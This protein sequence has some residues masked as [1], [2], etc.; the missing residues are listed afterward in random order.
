MNHFIF[1]VIV[2]ALLAFLGFI[3]FAA[4]IQIGEDDV[5]GNCN[6]YGKFVRRDVVY[7]CSKV[8]K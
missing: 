6:T 1:G 7:E 8:P 5:V 2:T 4:G 3:I